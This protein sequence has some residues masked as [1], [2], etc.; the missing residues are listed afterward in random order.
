MDQIQFM[1]SSSKSFDKGFKG[2]GKRLAVCLRV[3]LHDTS[4]SR[5]LLGLLK[6]KDMLF[7]DTAFEFNPSNVLS[8]NGLT[9]MRIKK[10]AY[11]ED[12]DYI[13]VNL[14]ELKKEYT[15]TNFADWWS[16]IV[17]ADKHRVKFSRRNLVLNVSNQDGGAHIDPDLDKEYAELTRFNSLGWIAVRSDGTTEPIRSRPD[18]SS[19]RQI[20][21]EVLISL[22]DEFSGASFKEYTDNLS[23]FRSER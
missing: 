9:V 5:S 21:H 4:K 22:A 12:F 10:T 20:A 3:L 14:G 2:E 8:T 19:I 6:K 18:L 13:P 16:K 15:K 23:R 11:G 7:Y 1:I 17:I